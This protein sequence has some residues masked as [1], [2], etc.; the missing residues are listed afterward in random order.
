MERHME[1]PEEED[2]SGRRGFLKRAAHLLGGLAALLLAVPA[3]WT[4]VGNIYRRTPVVY[5]PVT[6]VDALPQGQPVSVSFQ[7][8]TEEAYLRQQET[9]DVWV[10]KHSPTTITIFSSVCPHLGCHYDWDAGTQQFRCPCHNSI[11]TIDGKVISGPSPRPLDTL[12][13]RIENG[14]LFVAWERFAPGIPQKV[15]V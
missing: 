6:G 9:H 3:V 1:H 14:E 13:Y 8:K 5:S 4:M 15:Q 10:I 12:P 7:Y 11:F 2:P